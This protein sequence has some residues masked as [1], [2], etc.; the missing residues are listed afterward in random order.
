MTLREFEDLDGF[1]ISGKNFKN[2]GYADDTVL[3]VETEE[4][5][6]HY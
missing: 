1:A 5:L 2:L 6:Q 4:K 3:G